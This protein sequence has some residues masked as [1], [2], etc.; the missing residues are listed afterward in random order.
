MDIELS[1][2]FRV[3]MNPLSKLVSNSNLILLYPMIDL[4]ERNNFVDFGVSR[5]KLKVCKWIF[6]RSDFISRYYMGV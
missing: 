3:T 4:Y 6:Y 1:S 5:S 2:N